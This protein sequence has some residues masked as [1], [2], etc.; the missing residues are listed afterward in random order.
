MNNFDNFE[1]FIKLKKNPNLPVVNMRFANKNLFASL[2]SPEPHSLV[3]SNAR[4][5]YS[6]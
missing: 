2:D 4:N 6:T 1:R 5:H 3:T